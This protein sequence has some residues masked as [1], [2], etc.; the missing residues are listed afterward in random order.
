[1]ASVK[2]SLPPINIPVVDPRTGTVNTEWYR[3]F[4]TLRFRTGGDQDKVEA[5][6]QEVAVVK[7]DV[8]A[9][10]TGV[11]DTE[12]VAGNGLVGGGQLGGQIELSID[13]DGGYTGGVGTP[14]KGAFSTYIP[15]TPSGTYDPAQVS[16]LMQ[17]LKA[18]SERLLALEYSMRTVG[19]IE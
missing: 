10:E 3:F 17:N 2:T 16:D 19:V 15:P 18:T 5:T 7:E 14:N 9:I 1:M 13:A 8:A 12:I 6:V 11:T 4:E